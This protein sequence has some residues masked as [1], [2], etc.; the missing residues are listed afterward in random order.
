[1]AV[2]ASTF[3]RLWYNSISSFSF[4]APSITTTSY[5]DHCYNV[6]KPEVPLVS[7]ILDLTLFPCSTAYIICFP[8]LQ[9][10][11]LGVPK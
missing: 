2:F 11:P 9:K 7:M 1:V 5:K 6:I 8:V 3:S 4:E 10:K